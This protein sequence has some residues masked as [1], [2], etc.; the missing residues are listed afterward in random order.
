VFASSWQQFVRFRY[1][2]QTVDS[3]RLGVG[4]APIDLNGATIVDAADNA[5]VLRLGS[6]QSF[7]Y[8]ASGVR[9]DQDSPTVTSVIFESRP[10]DGRSYAYGDLVQVEVRFSE[11]V[12]VTGMPRLALAIGT[13]IRRAAFFSSAQEYVRFRYTVQEDDRDADGIAVADEGLSLNGGWILDAAGNAADLSLATAVVERPG[14]RVDGSSTSETVPVRAAVTS[15]PRSGG[16]YGLGESIDVEVQFNKEVTVD[17]QPQLELTIGSESSGE[18]GSRLAAA[19]ANGAVT[20]VATFVSS[21]NERLHFRYV[22]Q[23]EDSGLGGRVTIADDAL[24]LDRSTITDAAGEQ[25]AEDNLSL[26]N[27]EVIH[28][29]TVDGSMREPAVVERVSVTSTPQADDTY[30]SGESI[31]LEVG[32]S[33]SVTVTG[34]PQLELVFSSSGTA[35]RASFVAVDDHVLRF[36]HVVGEGDRDDD[37]IGIATNGLHLNNG[38]VLDAGGEA[39]S[40]SLDQAQIVIPA[41][42][43]DGR[44]A[45]TT[46]PLVE[47]V[48]IVSTPGSG[49]YRDSDVVSVEVTFSE[50]VTVTGAPQLALDVGTASRTAN[51]SGTASATVAFAYTVQVEDRDDDGIGIP[52][53]AVRLNGA[54]IRDSGDNDADLRTSE[55]QP[56]PGQSVN[57]GPRI[58][59]KQPGVAAARIV[60]MGPR[61]TTLAAGASRSGHRTASHAFELSLQ[62]E[63][64]LDGSGQPVELGCVALAAPNRQFRYAITAG[65]DAR[66]AISE[67]TGLVS[68]TGPGENAEQ[69]AEYELNVTA[70][71]A[72]AATV[73]MRLRVA[74]TN[75][76]DSGVVTL[77][78]LQPLTGS[79]VTATLTDQ[80]QVQPESTNWQWWRRKASSGAWTPI[81]AATAA[82]YTPVAGD[83]GHHL[84]A[85]VTYLDEHGSQQAESRQTEAVDLEPARRSRMLQLGLT[86]FGRTVGAAAVSVIGQRFVPLAS[87][88]ETGIAPAEVALNRRPLHVPGPGDSVALASTVRSVSEA[89]G[90]RVAA[91]GTVAFTPVS[92]MRLLAD[93]GFRV[94]PRLDGG[95]WGIWGNGDL[96]SFTSELDG[97]KQDG[98]VLTGYLGADYRFVPNALAGLAASYSNLDL[99]SA[100]GTEGDATLTGTLVSVYPYG[101]WMP[102]EWLG[103]W[104]LAGFGVGEA[105]LEDAG[106]SSDGAL[107]MW[108][109]AIG[110]RVELVSGGGLSLAA[111]TDGLITGV[112][113]SD[114]LPE[115]DAGAWRARLL[116]EGGFD[117]RPGDS[118]LAGSVELG[119]RL[120]G[121]DAETGLGAEGGAEF[122]YTHTG[123]GLGLAGRGRMLLVHEDTRIRDWGVSAG[124]SWQPPGLASGLALSAAPVWGQPTSGIGDLWQT[125]EMVLA[126]AG[127]GQSARDPASWLPDAMDLKMSYDLKLLQGAGRL[128]PFAAVALS[129]SAARRLRAGVTVDISDPAA[130]QRLQLEG[131]G[132][133]V[134]TEDA[135][136]YRFGIGGTVEY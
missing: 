74:I 84:Q 81:A 100:S 58:A 11:P 62:L 95:R 34:N 80:D 82:G 124:V 123:S 75:A 17:G 73:A 116:L 38:T 10:L 27:A 69:T 21:A 121:G 98:T 5:A 106:G 132:E 22:V 86:G 44:A 68:Y 8:E 24:R 56:D 42:S 83:G 110:Q 120:D 126:G 57:P 15:E 133:R 109:G 67:D 61:E 45:D 36:R 33:K 60:A 26:D 40:L 117:W 1:V 125:G 41:D 104:S 131:F 136:A 91:D 128:T 101:F 48:A 87:A 112:R 23:A 59:C 114:G 99:A 115:V 46:P 122:S 28:G 89:L 66:F 97:F 35:P 3:G 13:V 4:V 111:K 12:T 63:E 9:R 14:H 18:G 25:V 135:A 2:V 88:D 31:L 77:S 85:R 72:Q 64:N 37:G 107:R 108:L 16:T 102:A 130:T 55:V 43:V 52:A 39:V 20:R 113:S 54:T 119:G 127:G 19:P 90:V 50:A 93:S 53:N 118:R 103:V 47:S 32:F 105:K 49:G 129:D 29:D 30:R 51:F 70:T 6:A 76:N 96:S 134:A 79:E 65:D 7:A 94:A 78:R 92:G 71:D